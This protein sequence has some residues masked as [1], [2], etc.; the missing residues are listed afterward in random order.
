MRAI[1]VLLLASAAALIASTPSSEA[2]PYHP[3]CARYFDL[4]GATVCSFD[5]QAQCLASVGGIGGS[6]MSNAAPP[7]YGAAPYPQGP[8]ERVHRSKRRR[9]VER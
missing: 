7:P 9:H 1:V 4:S 3:W 8:Y 6:C 5:S 2:A